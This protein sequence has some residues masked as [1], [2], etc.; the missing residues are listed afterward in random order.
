MAATVISNANAYCRVVEFAA[1]TAQL[2]GMGLGS[3][4]FGNSETRQAI[5]LQPA[6]P[7]RGTLKC[8]LISGALTLNVQVTASGT[9]NFSSPT[10]TTGSISDTAFHAIE[11]VTTT[12]L[13]VISIQAV[14]GSSG[15]VVNRCQ[16]ELVQ[17]LPVGGGY[18]ELSSSIN[19][20]TVGAAAYDYL[21]S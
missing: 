16:L 19:G 9:T 13:P 10:A 7:V 1:G 4:T 12:S 17:K 14:S 6:K 5:D 18:H 3:K 21:V 15:A 2:P 11:F 8:T 20:T